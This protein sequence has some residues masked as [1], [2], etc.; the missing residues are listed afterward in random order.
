[1]LKLNVS[2][3]NYDE[4]ISP[5]DS[6]PC[7]QSR[8]LATSGFGEMYAVRCEFEPRHGTCQPFIANGDESYYFKHIHHCASDCMAQCSVDRCFLAINP[9]SGPASISRWTYNVYTGDC[10]TFNYSGCGGNANN[11][12]TAESCRAACMRA[13]CSMQEYQGSSACFAH[14]PLSR[15]YFVQDDYVTECKEGDYTG[16]IGNRNNFKTKAECEG[17]CI[18]TANTTTPG[19]FTVMSSQQVTLMVANTTVGCLIL[20]QCYQTQSQI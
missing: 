5:I 15:W 2:D 3:S 12:Y 6:T 18:Q 10:Q 17:L 8:D 1:M 4:P 13:P 16:C 19:D 9:G 20:H 11:F 14:S 7:L